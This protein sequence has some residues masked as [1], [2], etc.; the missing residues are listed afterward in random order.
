MSVGE[1]HKL[2]SVASCGVVA[3][4]TATLEAAFLGL[5]YC[6]V[7]KVSGFTYYLAKGLISVDFL[8]M[9]NLLAGRELVREFIQYDASPEKIAS[10]ILRLIESKEE[11]ELL[12]KELEA[13]TE[14]LADPGAYERAA[15]ATLGVNEDGVESGS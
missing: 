3:S 4:G 13:I 6:L 11:R 2:M 5:P 10:E 12:S 9:A 15:I 1:S 14:P 8:G 7:Y